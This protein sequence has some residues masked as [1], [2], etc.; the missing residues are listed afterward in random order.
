MIFFVERFSDGL[1]RLR[2]LILLIVGM[3][4]FLF[5]G[6]NMILVK[7]EGNFIINLLLIRI[8]I[9]AMIIVVFGKFKEF[10]EGSF[11]KGFI[12]NDV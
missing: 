9:V 12:L 8:I 5:Q 3:G 6:K 10:K 1:D 7:K 4:K 11:L 2:N